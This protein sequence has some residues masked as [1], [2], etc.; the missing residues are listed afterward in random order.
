MGL[1][2]LIVVAAIVWLVLSLLKRWLA[3]TPAADKP[4][5][6]RSQPMVKCAQC[7][8]YIPEADA[9]C[10]GEHCFCSAAHRQDFQRHG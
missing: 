6:G 1:F 9:I 2:R 10:E 3:E 7:G 5:P 4:E 8:L